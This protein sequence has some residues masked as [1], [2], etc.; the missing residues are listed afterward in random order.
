M[1]DSKTP[2]VANGPQTAPIPSGAD[3]GSKGRDICRARCHGTDLSVSACK[4]AAPA[5][6]FRPALFVF[7]GHAS[8]EKNSKRLFLF[9]LM[10]SKWVTFCIRVA[11]GFPHLMRNT[12]VF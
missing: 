2:H 9:T 4:Y 5:L 11:T 12:D 1:Q 7:A 8:G 10:F 3:L 6:L